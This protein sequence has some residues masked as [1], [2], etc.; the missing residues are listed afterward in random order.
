MTKIIE[1]IT[2]GIEQ[3]QDDD[4]LWRY[5]KSFDR[6]KSFLSGKIFLAPLSSYEDYFE[7]I[8]PTHF[9]LHQF[10]NNLQILQ[11]NSDSRSFSPFD[12]KN[13]FEKFQ[14][15][16]ITESLGRL[17][18]IYDQ[19]KIR[20][21]IKE[22]LQ[23]LPNIIE[24]HILLQQRT[25]ASCWF[26]SNNIEEDFL[27]WKSY[28]KV[29]GFAIKIK[30]SEFKNILNH[31][32]EL[33]DNKHFL[34]TSH[35]KLI[36]GGIIR[37]HNFMHGGDWIEG[38]KSVP[39]PFFKHSS[40]KNEKEFRLC[41]EQITPSNELNKVTFYDSML[42]DKCEIILHPSTTITEYEKYKAL[43]KK[44]KLN[45]RPRFSNIISRCKGDEK[46]IVENLFNT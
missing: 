35:T 2:T 38:I 23:N 5:F 27:M 42:W 24:N 7:S 34:D 37:Y 46:K 20:Q 8:T 16:W 15:N 26:V 44:H 32:L 43:L 45:I 28:S 31:S 19:E 17:W 11:A 40:Y 33:E 41:V 36:K 4:Y 18:N 14:L 6:L 25:Y 12:F 29:G 9:Y 13:I 1:H 39:L 10:I 22:Q 30:Y 21:I 3:P